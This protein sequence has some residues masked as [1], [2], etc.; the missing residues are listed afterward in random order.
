[1]K[2]YGCPKGFEIPSFD[3]TDWQKAEADHA[4]RL[5]KHFIDAGHTGEYT[6]EIISF[7]VA[8]GSAQYMLVN[9]SGRYGKSAFLIHLAYGDG[10]SYNGINHFPKAEIIRMAKQARSREA[11]FKRAVDW[12]EQR[13]L[14]EIVHYHNSFGQFVRGEIV[15]NPDRKSTRLNSSHRP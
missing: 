9:G 13:K 11:L 12:W 2:V 6:G 14:G 1:M 15:I 3:V 7:G 5:K 10:Y 4:A 8:D